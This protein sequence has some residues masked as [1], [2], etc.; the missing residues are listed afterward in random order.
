VTLVVCVGTAT[1][2]GKTWVGAAVL[3][4]LRA[5]GVTVAARKPVQSF[6]AADRGPTDADVLAA[7]TGAHPHDVCPG[8]RWYP[9]AM[10]P[11]M[12]A[13][14]LARK[15]FTVAALAAEIRWPAPTPSVRWVET[16]GGVRSPMAF[17]GDSVDLCAA[18]DPDLVVLVADA[19]LG[20]INAVRLSMPALERW[21]VIVVLN[22]FDAGDDIH[23]LNR[24]WL[25]DRDGY[26]VVTSVA[27]L[28]AEVGVLAPLSH[29]HSPEGGVSG[30]RP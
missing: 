13:A 27:E 26:R 16:V 5:D 12:A 19:G 20:T 21:P 4:Q 11:P 17:D 25:T 23:A 28:M 24:A 30:G 9:V 10:A 8:S 6:D 29:Q 7:A 2:V 18:V 1:D 3:A 14:V 15:P 22:R